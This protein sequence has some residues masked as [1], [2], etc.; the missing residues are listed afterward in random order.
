M[1]QIAYTA[2]S[3]LVIALAGSAAIAY[4]FQS[5][6]RVIFT[7]AGMSVGIFIFLCAM[8]LITHTG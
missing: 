6:L 5:R 7:F 8:A 4:I 3:I 1:P 2:G